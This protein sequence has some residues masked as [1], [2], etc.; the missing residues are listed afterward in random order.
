MTSNESRVTWC[1][2][3]PPGSLWLQ[4]PPALRGHVEMDEESSGVT[5]SARTKSCRKE[6]PR[7]EDEESAESRKCHRKAKEDRGGKSPDATLNPCCEQRPQFPFKE[8][9][10]EARSDYVFSI[11]SGALSEILTLLPATLRVDFMI[12]FADRSDV[13]ASQSQNETD[14]HDENGHDDNTQVKRDR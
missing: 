8:P 12:A 14:N 4:G 9:E 2:R 6:E 7:E 11:G 13:K 10:S 5:S 3:L 1:A